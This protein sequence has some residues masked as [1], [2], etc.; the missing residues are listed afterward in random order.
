M[1]AWREVHLPEH[2]D[3]RRTDGGC[4]V[5][6]TGKAPPPVTSPGPLPAG[7][8]KTADREAITYQTVEDPFVLI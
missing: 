1:R 4:R 5:M 8:K 2:T 7:G 3:G 6:E